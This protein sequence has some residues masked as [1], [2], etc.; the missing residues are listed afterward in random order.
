MAKIK[1][2]INDG[3]RAKAVDTAADLFRKMVLTKEFSEFL[4]LP[5]YD[6]VVSHGA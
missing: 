2:G 3:E 6:W 5:A 4:T 1:H